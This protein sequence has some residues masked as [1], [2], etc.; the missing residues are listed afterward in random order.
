MTEKLKTKKKS[1]LEKK[2]PT[3]HQKWIEFK[4]QRNQLQYKERRDFYK[5]ITKID[6]ENN[7]FSAKCSFCNYYKIKTNSAFYIH[8]RNKAIFW[9]DK[10][11]ELDL[12]CNNCLFDRKDIEINEN[13]IETYYVYKN[14]Y[15]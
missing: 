2:N 1:P 15:F 4:N 10:Y 5:P 12:V 6:L 13:Q 8:N 7:A 14:R 9:N 11:K 3:S